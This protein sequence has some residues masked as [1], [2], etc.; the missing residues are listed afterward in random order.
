MEVAAYLRQISR[1]W[2][3]V[4]ALALYL[5]LALPNLDRPGLHYD[6]AL[7][8]ATPATLLLQGQ[9]FPIVNNGALR[10]GD[11]RLPLMVQNHIGAIQLYAA[12]P[13]VALLGPTTAALRTM[14]V[15]VGAATVI[16]LYVLMLRLYGRAAAGAAVLWLAAFPSFVLWSRQGVFVTNLAPCLAVWAFAVAEFGVKGRRPADGARQRDKETRRLASSLGPS[17]SSF[18]HPTSD[19]RHL[20]AF[21]AGLLAGLAVWAKLSALWLVFGALAW[22]AILLVWRNWRT[23]E[24]GS[25]GRRKR[26]GKLRTGYFSLLAG[27]VL[28]CLPIIVY[29]LVTGFK[30]FAVVGASASETYL[31]VSNRNVISNFGTRVAQFADVVS[32]GEHLW[33][34][35]GQF[36]NTLALIS[37]LVALVGIVVLLV[38]Q[39]G[40]GW[41]RELFLPFLVFACVVQS[42]FTISALWYTHFAIAVWLPAAVVG[43]AAGAGERWVRSQGS[44]ARGQESKNRHYT[45]RNTQHAAQQTTVAAIVGFLLLAVVPQAGST[46][47]YLSAAEKTG[48]LSFHSTAIEDVSRFLDSR[49]EPV[50][51]LDW[52]LSAQIEYLTHGRKRVEEAYGFSHDTPPD[53]AARLQERFGRGELY[54]TH[55]VNEEAFPRRQAFLDAVAAAGLQAET[56]NVSVRKDGLPLIEVWRVVR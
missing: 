46:L 15:I 31:G 32:S 6:E 38:Q 37:F 53:F 19:I 25:G 50:V 1:E 16:G 55:V 7:E 8:A 17:A 27:F 20:P 42:C 54:V 39:R 24:S 30:T 34:L 2:A 29:N 51:A 36:P 47:A 13:F 14:T 4:V 44:G 3:L 33:Y 40:Y 21:V 12:L 5:T 35:G 56:V 49:T 26:H 28:G 23:A 22:E 9:Q 41:Q 10:I 11:V 48:G 45:L 43:V 18:P 52:G